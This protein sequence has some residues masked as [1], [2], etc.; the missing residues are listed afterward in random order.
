MVAA[1]FL[2]GL[3]S[4]FVILFSRGERRRNR[5]RNPYDEGDSR[6][7]IWAIA[8]LAVAGFLFWNQPQSG[9]IIAYYLEAE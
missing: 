8:M 4:L 7:R 3:V 2:I 6:M 5:R 9:Q 1:L